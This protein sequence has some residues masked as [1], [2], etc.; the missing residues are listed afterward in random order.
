MFHVKGGRMVEAT[1]VAFCDGQPT[2]FINRK[3]GEVWKDAEASTSENLPK[4]SGCN[5]NGRFNIGDFEDA[6]E[7][8]RKA[9]AGIIGIGGAPMRATTLPDEAKA[10]KEYPVA[11]GFLDYF[12]DAVVAVSNVSYRGGQQH[13]PDKPLHWDRAKSK[14]ESDTMMRHFLQRGTLDTD[15]VRHTAK[16][17]WRLLAILQKEIEEENQKPSE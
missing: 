15:G 16:A 1:P 11:S 9:D 10:R 6:R 5:I 4:T 14:D 3:T 13:H 8:T 7:K 2:H 12:P 17:A